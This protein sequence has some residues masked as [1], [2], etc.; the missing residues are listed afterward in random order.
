M[1]SRRVFV[2]IV[3][4]ALLSTP[5]GGFAQNASKPAAESMVNAENLRSRPWSH[6]GRAP[7]A[8]EIKAWDIDVRSDFKGL[9]AGSGSVAK[10]Q[11]VWESKCESCHGTFGESNEVFT[12]IVGHTTQDDIKTGRVASLR[13]DNVPQRTTMMKLPTLSTLWDYINR[14]MPWNA[15]KTLSVE[16]VYAV[17][18]YVLHLADIVSADFVLKNENMAEIQARLPNR[19]GMVL[20]PGLWDRHGKPDVQGDRCMR[21]C[22]VSGEIRSILPDYARDAHGNLAEQQRLVG[23]MRGAQTTNIAVAA[24][25]LSTSNSA[26][27]SNLDSKADNAGMAALAKSANCLA[28]HG[29]SNRIIGPSFK[30][31]ATRYQVQNTAQELLVTRVRI[32]GQGV[33][34]QIP[35]PPHP[36]LKDE[37]IEKLVRWILSGA[38]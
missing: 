26:G 3:V 9:P 28:C 27:P 35:M 8:A 12:P 24:A 13:R 16:E 25:S 23:P 33:W 19:N 21:N 17:T 31:V 18:A 7:T 32:G 30:E 14:A 15:P 1:L 6:L 38:L 22:P 37:E 34:G 36:G 11:E 29:L 5:L 20:Q 10:G 4:L 2:A